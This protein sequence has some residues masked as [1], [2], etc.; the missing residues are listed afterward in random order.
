[1]ARAGERERKRMEQP[2]NDGDEQ[3]FDAPLERPD[4]PG[5]WT[6]VRAPGDLATIYGSRG[7]I[8]VIGSINGYPY[9]GSAMPFGDGTHFLVVNKAIRDALGVDVGSVVRM[10]IR[11]D[12]TPREIEAPA[13]LLAALSDHQAAQAYYDRLAPSHRKL[14]VEWIEDAKKPET[15]ARRVQGAIERLAQG[16]PLK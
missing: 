1:M 8:K 15:R 10:T 6:Y 16:R 9:R 2:S 3:T 13:D 11:P 5:A 4:A 14:Y 12:T 7:S